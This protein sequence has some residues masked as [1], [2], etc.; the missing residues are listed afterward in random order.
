MKILGAVYMVYLII[1]TIVPSK[2]EVQNNNGSFIIGAFLQFINPKIMIYGITAFSSFILPHYN[3]IP[4]LVFFAFF[5]LFVGFTGSICWALFGSLF[6]MVFN[7]HTKVL[8][9]IMVV[10]LLYCAVSLFL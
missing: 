4:V 9:V 2:H 8:N 3:N 5:L 10:L 7:K 1:K 6:S